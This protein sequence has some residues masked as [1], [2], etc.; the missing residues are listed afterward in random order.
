MGNISNPVVSVYFNTFTDATASRAANGTVYQNT[1]G[2]PMCVQV[3]CATAVNG[4]ITAF[5]D[6]AASP[7]T[8]CAA[9]GSANTGAQMQQ[10]CTFVVPANYYYKVTAT[11]AITKWTEIT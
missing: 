3:T 9:G 5:C 4:T 10:G 8:Q 7:T 11:G 1:S 6:S 2:K